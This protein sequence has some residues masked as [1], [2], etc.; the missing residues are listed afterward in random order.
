MQKPLSEGESDTGNQTQKWAEVS[1]SHVYLAFKDSMSYTY[2]CLGLELIL[3]E[4]TWFMVRPS[5]R[6]LL[7]LVLCNF[8]MFFYVQQM[9]KF[10][11]HT[12]ICVIDISSK[13]QTNS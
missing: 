9:L 7:K 2:C 12:C 6:I 8:Y 10:F 4:F 13:F 3:H 11:K 1:K 5:C